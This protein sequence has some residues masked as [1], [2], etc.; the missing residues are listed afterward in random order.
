MVAGCAVGAGLGAISRRLG[1]G[2]GT[3]P[4]REM[5]RWANFLSFFLSEET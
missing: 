3:P 5:G 1:G 4:L 2:G